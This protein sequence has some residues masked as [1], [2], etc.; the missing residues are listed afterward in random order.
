MINEAKKAERVT[1]G[2]REG[3]LKNAEEPI[4]EE[5]PSPRTWSSGAPSFPMTKTL[6]CS[7]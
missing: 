7:F 3:G 6:E 5:K 2:G 4:R 1:R